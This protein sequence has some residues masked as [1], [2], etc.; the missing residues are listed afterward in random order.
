MTPDRAMVHAEIVPRIAG[1][2][3]GRALGADH[4]SFVDGEA[5]RMGRV[6][7]RGQPGTIAAQRFEDLRRW[8]DA[9]L[10]AGL[11][12]RGLRSLNYVKAP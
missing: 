2:D 7:P 9:S 4:A 10:A 12:E 3:S 1:A 11:T 8:L 6:D 5:L